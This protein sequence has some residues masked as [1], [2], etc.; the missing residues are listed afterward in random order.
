MPRPMTAVERAQQDERF[1]LIV[2]VTIMRDWLQEG[3][4][5]R[6]V[7]GVIDAMKSGEYDSL[8]QGNDY[9]NR[10]LETLHG[11]DTEGE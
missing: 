1:R 8:T 7:A 3:C 9:A 5:R 4:C 6:V 2:L 11:I 10:I